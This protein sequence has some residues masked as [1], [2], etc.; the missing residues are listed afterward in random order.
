MNRYYENSKTI[1]LT[2]GD[3]WDLAFD[4]NVSVDGE[5]IDDYTATFHV[6]KNLGLRSPLLISTPL[7]KEGILTF[8]H[9]MTAKLE[10]G[11]YFYD[12]EIV[13]GKEVMTWG[14]FIFLLDP[15]V[16]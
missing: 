12:I 1:Q 16:G 4:F 10:A 8:T 6:K 14:P 9:E 3:T 7:S 15:D 13:A 11:K 2:R 5:K